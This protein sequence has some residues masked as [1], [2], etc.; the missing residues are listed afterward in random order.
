MTIIELHDVDAL[1]SDNP[2]W[3]GPLGEFLADNQLAAE[4][5]TA[6]RELEPGESTNVGGGAGGLFTVERV[7]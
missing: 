3:T 2:V 1:D 4:E 5:E 6:C 7:R